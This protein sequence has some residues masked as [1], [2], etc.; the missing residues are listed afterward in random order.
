MYGFIIPIIIF[1]TITGI[2]NFAQESLEDSL[3]LYFVYSIASINI[4]TAILQTVSQYLTMDK[5]GH[6]SVSG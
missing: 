1:S 2:G 6:A 4:I 3:K 5:E